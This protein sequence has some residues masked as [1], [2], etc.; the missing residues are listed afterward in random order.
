MGVPRERIVVL[1]PFDARCSAWDI[2]RDVT[3][4]ASARQFASILSP[5]DK[6]STQPF[7]ANAAQDLLATVINVLRTRVPEA[8]TLNDALEA[9]TSPERLRQVLSLTDEGRDAMQVYLD[10]NEKTAGDVLSTIRTKLAPYATAARLWA[11]SKKPSISLSAWAEEKE[12]RV[13]LVGTDDTNAA[14]LDAINRAIFRRASELVC[15]RS[16][17]E[18]TLPT[19]WFFIDEARWAGELDS[20]QGL[21]LKGRSKGARVVLGFQDIQGLRHVYG[22]EQADELVG[23]CGNIAVLRLNSPET[24]S[25]AARYFGKYEEYIRSFGTSSSRGGSG[26]T[27]NWSQSS[28]ENWSM[29]ERYS[30]LEQDFRLFPMP[31]LMEGI[32][33]AFAYPE[34]AWKDTIPPSF[35]AMYLCKESDDDGF[36]ARDPGEQERL[37]WSDQL[38]AA[39]N[40]ETTKD[41]PDDEEPP[42]EGETILTL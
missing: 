6:S 2:A 8:W 39:L 22:R 40:S 5:L 19:T 4:A 16:G 30:I 20:L 23:Q 1:H 15:A 34:R 7:F 3:D 13:L 27:S 12:P 41:T 31:T 21:L 35:V 18:G 36:E 32:T 29:Q 28:S 38:K 33:G 11:R 24:M 17:K 42:K 25:W 10:E 37:P 26:G 14:S 9:L